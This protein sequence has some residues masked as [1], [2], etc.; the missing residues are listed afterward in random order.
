MKGV[1]NSP[2]PQDHHRLL[3]VAISDIVI[4]VAEGEPA[5]GGRGYR[6]RLPGQ[7]ESRV[8]RF[9]RAVEDAF[10]GGGPKEGFGVGF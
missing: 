8:Y 3:N 6:G 10:L 1:S 7:G 5:C 2:L 9:V 4:Q